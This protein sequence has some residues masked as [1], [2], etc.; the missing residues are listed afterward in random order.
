MAGLVDMPDRFARLRPVFLLAAAGLVLRAVYWADY[1]GFPLFD[2]AVGPDVSEYD[3]R[4][5]EILSGVFLPREAEIH[6][7]LYSW[8]LA[9]LYQLGGSSIP[10]VRA[11]QLLL[12]WGSWLGIYAL[13]NRLHGI[14]RKAPLWFLALAMLYPVPLFH[15]AELI[16]EALLLPL[17]AGTLA[18]LYVAERSRT[19]SERLLRFP[20]AGVLAGLAAITHPMS[21]AFLGAEL[22]WFGWRKRFGAAMLVLAGALVAILPVSLVNSSL[23]GR[24]VLIQANSAFN[25]W[26]GNNP[27][28]TGSCYIRPGT[29]WRTLHREA[30]QEAE[31]RGV[32]VDRVWTGRVFSFWWNHPLDALRLACVKAGK[33]WYWR[34]LTAGA[35]PEFLIRRS[36][37][38]RLG[39]VLT[40]PLF[41]FALIGV[42]RERKR[43]LPCRHFYLLL[44][45]LFLMQI[46]TVT[47]GRYRL[48]MLPAV[49]FF[50]ACALARFRWRRHWFVLP[51]LLAVSLLLQGSDSGRAEA[52]ALLGEAA[53]RK[54]E[55]REAKPLLE[56]ALREID[57]VPRFGNL[58]GGIAMAE[59]DAVGAERAFRQVLA[60][61]PLDADAHMNLGNLCS[62]LPGR[63]GEA[64][65]HYRRALALRPDYADLHFNFGL[66]LQRQGRLPEAE[67][68]YRQALECNPAHAQAF[69]SLGILAMGRGAFREAAEFFHRAA[70]LEP[71]NP[72]FAANRRAAQE[73]ANAAEK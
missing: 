13:L 7:P 73:A 51:L 5:R 72:G 19:R 69:N 43:F 46:L 3:A 12:N 15:Q 31:A 22:L 58:L 61:D 67:K 63:A 36:V 37:L 1:A 38:I 30:E 8:F 9:L 45:A 28:A 66:F 70:S 53:F 4:A 18:A 20:L 44:G 52:A 39:G 48:A 54:G 60:A 55:F 42:L 14:P 71:G 17:L 62:V 57:D 23:A 65:E 59:G 68:Q 32:T 24:P 29:Q 25:L 34:E 6:A 11:V 10:L 40:L 27:E 64:E 50:A 26:L 56:Q 47:S 41:V 35:D 49:L 21:L 33:V 16:S 2:L